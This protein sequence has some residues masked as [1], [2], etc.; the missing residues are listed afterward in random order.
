MH[1]AIKYVMAVQGHPRLL[2]SVT[3]ENAYATFYRSSLAT[4]VLCCTVA[5]IRRQS[6]LAEN[7]KFSL[8]HSYLM[9]WMNLKSK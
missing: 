1:Y 4:L 7:R 3:I 9:L 5:E 2:I 8:P 6:L